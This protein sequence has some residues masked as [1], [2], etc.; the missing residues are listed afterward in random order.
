[1]SSRLFSP[2]SLRSLSLPN[3]VVIAP[4]CQYSAVDGRVQP[5]HLAHLGQYVVSGA[6]LLIVE[7]TAVEASGRITAG[8]VGLYDE[9]T[10]NALGELMQTLRRV[11]PMRMAIQLAHA[12]RKASS[13]RPWEGGSLVRPELGGWHPAGPSALAVSEL[14]PPP[15]ALSRD[16][17]QALI[18]RFVDSTLRADH[19]GF[20]AVELHAAHGYLLHQFLSPIA[21]QREDEYGG[22]LENRMRFPLAVFAAMRAAWPAHKPMGVRLSATDWVADSGWDVPQAIEFAQNL[23]R[24]GADWIDVSS[25]G[26]S[27]RQQI[28]IGP[29]YQVPFA[30]AIRAAVKIPVMAVGLI[31]EPQQAE[32]ILAEGKADLVALARGM[33]YNPRWVW[34]AAAALGAQIEAPRQYWRSQPR[35]LADLFGKTRFGAR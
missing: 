18:A 34:H 35:E 6:G 23:E 27:P 16:D 25:G 19:L 13:A 12:G 10:E 3:R 17:I 29:G 5:W 14:E 33:L 32:D 24:L 21:N 30:Q 26:V 1:M 28:R 7:A 4:M 2:L 8:C 15:R 9:A 31:T 11:A 22:S 20:D